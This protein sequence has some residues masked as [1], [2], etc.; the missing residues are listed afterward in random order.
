MEKR[1]IEVMIQNKIWYYCPV[2]KYLYFDPK[3]IAGT[4]SLRVLTSEEKAELTKQV[5]AHLNSQR[6]RLKTIELFDQ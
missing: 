2:N 4:F 6:L 1:L 5:D 3:G